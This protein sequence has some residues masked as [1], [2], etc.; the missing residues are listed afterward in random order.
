MSTNKN[1]YETAKSILTF[2]GGSE[3][4]ISAAHCATR[5]R[6]VLKD[7]TIVENKQIE[8]LD[9]VKGIFSNGG[10]YQIILGQG[11]VNHVYSE[12]INLAGITEMSTSDIKN[13]AAK[14]LNPMQRLARTLSNIFVPIIPAI[15][16]A[17]LLMGLLGAASKFGLDQYA[18]SW[19]WS[20]LDWFSSAAFIF[21]PILV[22]ISAAKVFGANPYLAAT[23]G[24]IMIHPALQNAWT[25]GQGFKT[26]TVLGFIDMPLLGY[27]GTVLPILVVVFF[28]AYIEKFIR[29]IVPEVLDI[30][31]TPLFTVL[32]TG[33]LALAIIGPAANFIGHGISI[34][35]T[36]ALDKFGVI[37]G[38]LFGGTYS[39]IV[40]TGIHH[41]FHAIEL[42]LL[43]DTGVNTLLPIWS[44][45]NFA[46]GGAALAVYFMSK[47]SKIKSIA[48]P[49]AISA[50]VGIT[51]AAIFGVNLRYR[52]PFI[53]AAIGGAA[54]GAYVVLTKVSMTAV[55]VTGI[56]GIAIVTTSAMM[57]YIIGLAIALVVS[58]IA[59][60]ML[61]IKEEA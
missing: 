24:G 37:A 58:F 51:E 33:F 59:T 57:N 54:A 16:A 35:L 1:Y 17:G 50:F 28:M 39:A 44:M 10:Q 26:M 45:A 12:F 36:F 13:E 56:P 23:V 34:F 49:S 52:K 3:N 46:Q 38:L 22:A 43:A 20:M 8:G 25:Q 40:I 18:G 29:K 60:Y 4:V 30:L 19:W 48:L 6:L 55:G 27:Q 11:I 9:L 32:I 15:V 47:N 2:I 21:L 53:G 5:L 31:L 7:E 41:S 14:K 61:G 42:G